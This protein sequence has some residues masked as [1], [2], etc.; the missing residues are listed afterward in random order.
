MHMEENKVFCQKAK[1]IDL[2]DNIYQK[3]INPLLD[4]SHSAL[5][6]QL[7]IVDKLN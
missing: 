5:V 2:Q 3:H 4:N 6:V 7:Y 1:S